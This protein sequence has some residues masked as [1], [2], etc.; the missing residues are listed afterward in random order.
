M[1]KPMG[2][3]MGDERRMIAITYNDADAISMTLYEK[4]Y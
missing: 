3:V 1:L 2:R 4:I